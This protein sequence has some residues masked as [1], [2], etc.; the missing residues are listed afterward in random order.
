MVSR[1]LVKEDMARF[2]PIGT[3]VSAVL[4]FWLV[5]HLV[6]ALIALTVVPLTLISTLGVMGYSGVEITMLTSTLPTLLLCMSVADG[7][8]M[9]GRF[10]EERDRLDGDARA[11]A[12]QRS[13]RCSCRAC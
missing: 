10:L 13:R 12:A 3:A 7:L 6:L 1:Q 5:P 2:L 11:A 4:L 8:H 9:V